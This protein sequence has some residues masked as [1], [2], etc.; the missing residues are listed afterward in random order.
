MLPELKEVSNTKNPIEGKVDNI[1]LTLTWNYK[2][3]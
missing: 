3:K 2:T 1:K